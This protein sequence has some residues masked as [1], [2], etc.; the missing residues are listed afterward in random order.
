MSLS[1][2]SVVFMSIFISGMVNTVVNTSDA[3]APLC[4]TAQSMT[5]QC[6]YYDAQQCRQ[7]AQKMNGVCVPNPDEPNVQ[8]GNSVYCKFRADKISECIYDDYNACNRE[9]RRDGAV[10]VRNQNKYV[11]PAPFQYQNGVY[12]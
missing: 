12:N 8:Q 2:G 4:V 9:A 10:C 7:A 6:Y 5:S 3:A 11:P 1:V